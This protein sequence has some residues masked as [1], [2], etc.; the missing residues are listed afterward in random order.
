MVATDVTRIDYDGCSADVVFYKIAGG[1]HSWPGGPELP[2]WFV[3]RTTHSIDATELMWSFFQ[4]PST[5][6]AIMVIV[7]CA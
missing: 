6:D 2:E 5:T 1:G 3:G 4:G 7:R